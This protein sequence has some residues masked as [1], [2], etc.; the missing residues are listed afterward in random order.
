MNSTKY[1]DLCK[2]SFNKHD[3]ISITSC[4]RL[5]LL[6]YFLPKI[7]AVSESTEKLLAVLNVTILH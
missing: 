5:F 3:P 1:E 2:Q 7:Q 4:E 6:I